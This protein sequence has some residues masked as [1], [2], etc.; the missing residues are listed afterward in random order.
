MLLPLEDAIGYRYTTRL[1]NEALCMAT[2]LSIDYQPYLDIPGHPA[3]VVKRRMQMF[4]REIST[5]NA[6]LICNAYQRL[7]TD[8][9]RWAPRSLLGHRTS[10]LG[11]IEDR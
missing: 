1:S 4:L 2:M 5:F 10:A 11:S 9:Y 6:G 7:P 3:D 8:G